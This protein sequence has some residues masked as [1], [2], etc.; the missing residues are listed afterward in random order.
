MKQQEFYE[1]S[2]Q[3]QNNV[4]AEMKIHTKLMREI[5]ETKK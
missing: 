4:L 3:A 5:L 1:K 2:I